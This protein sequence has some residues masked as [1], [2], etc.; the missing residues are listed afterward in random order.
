M[1]KRVLITEIYHSIQGESTWAGLPCTFIRFARCN[2]RCVWCDTTY[3]FTGGTEMSIEEILEQCASYNCS[4]VEITGGEPLAQAVCIDLA[5]SLIAGGYT[6]LVET[7]GSLPIAPLPD[8]AISIMDLKCPG[9]GECAK[10]DYSNI[11]ALTKKDEVK[12]VITDRV[13][14]EWARE[15]VREYDLDT[16]CNAVLFSPVF[17]LI[18][19]K[20]I[21]EW[22]TE[23]CLPVRFQLQMHKFIWPPDQKGV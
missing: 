6:V 16:R 11:D 1:S 18:D 20:T 4:L 9:S 23:D 2:L 17:D 19:P 21:V 22:I 10:N 12:F 5:E 14:Y 7:S 3:S 15:K 13:D 8:A